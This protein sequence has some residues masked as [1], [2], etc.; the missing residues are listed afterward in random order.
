[1]R[2]ELE[3]DKFIA[4]QNPFVNILTVSQAAMIS[5]TVICVLNNTK[6]II[7]NE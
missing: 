3:Q 2:T 4:I 1:M 6:F 5:A 7:T